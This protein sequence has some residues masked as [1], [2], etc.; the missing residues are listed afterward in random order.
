MSGNGARIRVPKHVVARAFDTETIVL[1]L[2]TGEY[3]GLNQTAA[4]MFELL[5]QHGS[6]PAVAS[7]VANELGQ[8]VDEVAQDVEQLCADLAWRDLLEIDGAT[9]G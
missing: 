3:H 9:H 1:N 4:R 6:V 8:P 2:K 7:M 5:R